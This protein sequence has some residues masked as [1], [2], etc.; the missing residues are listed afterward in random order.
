[1]RSI[2]V[3]LDDCE[4]KALR[5]LAEREDRDP[6]QQAARF[7]REGLRRE[8]LLAGESRP[9]DRAGGASTNDDP[10]TQ[11]GSA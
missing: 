7:I 1:V 9:D 6:R 4:R 3:P 10:G 11:G 8:G 5:D 2:Y